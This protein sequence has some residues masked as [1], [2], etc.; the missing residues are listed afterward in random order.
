MNKDQGLE[1]LSTLIDK[2]NKQDNRCTAMP[3]Y[4][5]IKTEKWRVCKEGYGSG[6]T[7]TVRVDF[8]SDP[9]VY[10]SK[11]EFVK[12]YIE[13]ESYELEA[14]EPLD[15]FERTDPQAVLVY[16]HERADY[17]SSLSK[18]R[19]DAESAWEDLEEFEE[20]KF[21]EEENVFFTEEAFKEHVRVNGHNLGR[22][23]EYYSYVKH[24]FRNDELMNLLKAISAV[25]GKELNYK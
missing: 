16:E 9:T 21:Y 10:L 11:E 22:R 1:F 12:E 3:Y 6:E 4:Y 5:V 24:A 23:G 2:I 18:L 7:R 13:R 19:V 14:P 8:N 17:E 25:T 20:E 15:E